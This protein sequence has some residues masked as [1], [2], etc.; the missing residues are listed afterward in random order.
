MLKLIETRY[1]L[2]QCGFT[3]ARI[4][5]QSHL[6]T[7]RDMQVYTFQH[8]PLF[9]IA[10]DHIFKGDIALEPDRAVIWFYRVGYF[11]CLVEYLLDALGPGRGVTCQRGQL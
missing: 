7:R 6:A 8:G 4:A 10:K 9:R 2:D 11:W 5:N 1:Q 3:T